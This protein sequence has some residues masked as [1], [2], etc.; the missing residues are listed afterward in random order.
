MV[1][2]ALAILV[3]SLRGDASH[4]VAL[5][6]AMAWIKVPPE[7]HPLFRDALPRDR[8]VVTVPMFGGVVA[9]VNGNTFA[10]LFQRS[11]VVW[12]PEETRPEALALDGAAPF[13]PLGRGWSSS[14]KIMLPDD[15]MDDAPEL[16]AWIA[17]AF[18]AASALP[19]K[20][21]KPTKLAKL[22]EPTTNPPK[23]AK[24]MFSPA[25]ARARRT[26]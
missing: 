5:P 2:S 15:M 11:V 18:E 20:A 6:C 13:D 22:A 26:R 1:A 7:H 17:R 23:A 8:R 9:K 25:A 21:A 24:P 16:R 19:P 14:D 3:M 12:L 4:A 10:G